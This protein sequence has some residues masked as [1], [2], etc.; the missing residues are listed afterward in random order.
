[1]MRAWAAHAGHRG[2]MPE[3]SLPGGFGRALRDGSILPGPDA[4]LGTV[5]FSDWLNAQPRG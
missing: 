5:A 2:W 4:D 3:I 1:M